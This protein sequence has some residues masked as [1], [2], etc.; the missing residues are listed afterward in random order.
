MFT[1]ISG[2]LNWILGGTVAVLLASG[3]WMI[4]DYKSQAA[5]IATLQA[6]L[7]SM[8]NANKVAK[9]NV[10]LRDDTIA[11][12]NKRLA[13]RYD[14]LSKTCDLLQDAVQD[15]SPDADKPVGGVLG[16]ILGKIDGATAPK[17]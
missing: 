2:I 7:G 11:T 1:G 6:Q 4:H 14:D 16:D 9:A 13:Q 3:M 15:K 8:Q 17:K 12:L 5:K 10:D